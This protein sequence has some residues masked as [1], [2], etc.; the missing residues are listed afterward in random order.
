MG[1]WELIAIALA[2]TIVLLLFVALSRNEFDSEAPKYE[3]LGLKPPANPPRLAA[4][5]LGPTDRIIRLGAIGAAFY[6][7]GRFGWAEPAGLLLAVFGL[8][9][10]LTG[11]L[12]LD[13]FYY[14]R[15]QR[16]RRP[17]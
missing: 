6:Y 13:P 11:L 10:L 8:Y 5:H 7:A 9:L 15:A 14:W 4:G 1:L 17:E 12:G 2:I 16:S 3:M